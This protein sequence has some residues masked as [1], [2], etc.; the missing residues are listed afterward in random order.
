M[1]FNLEIPKELSHLKIDKRGYP[2][3]F[4]VSWINGEPEFRYLDAV[5]A[6]MIIDNK[7]CHIC[8]KKLNKDF[9]YFISGPI[10]LQNRISSDAAMHKTCAEFSLRACPHLYLQ[11]A[12]RRDNDELGK[13]IGSMPSPVI[14]EKPNTLF[15]IKS[16]K[17]KKVLHEGQTYL[18]YR[19]VSTEKYIY[20]NGK[21]IKELLQSL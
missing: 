9:F 20:E 13:A 2:V 12:D 10:G 6:K 4:F 8:G 11:K 19:P 17:F 5:R 15:L 3:P 16:N 7:L 1:G 18:Q 21:L 14:R